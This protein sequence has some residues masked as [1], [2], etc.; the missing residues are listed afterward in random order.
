MRSSVQAR[1]PAQLHDAKAA[2]RW[3][4]AHAA[5]HRLDPGRFA[6]MG[7]SSGGWLALMAAFTGDRPELEGGVGLS[8]PSSRVQA[9]VD[10]YGPTDFLQMDA[11]TIDRALFNRAFGISGGHDDPGS[12]ES[13][14]VGGPIRAR[15]EAVRAANPIT[16]LDGRAPPVA[17][18]HGTDDRFVP[19]H[20]SELLYAALRSSGATAVFFS[21]PGVGHAHPYLGDAR[22]AAGHTVRWTRTGRETVT[23]GRPAPTWET[24]ERLL[25]R[26]LG[27]S[28]ARMRRRSA[29]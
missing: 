29:G 14:L 9:A 13:M 4:R 22:A 7:A 15:P 28:D 8:G 18:L 10:L 20:Q 1:F 25:R 17:I 3:L 26:V 11:H 24:I 2:I 19:H 21:I 12:P 16:Y 27:R 6:I 5:E 23:V